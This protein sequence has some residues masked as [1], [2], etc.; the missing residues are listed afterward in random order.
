MTSFIDTNIFIYAS[1]AHPE[2]GS[3][4]RTILERVHSGEQAVTSTLV[5]SEVAWVLEAKGVQSQIKPTLERITSINNLDIV[6]YSLDDMLVA[7]TYMTSYG[8]DYN[9]AVNVSVMTRLNI[10]T[11]YTNDKKH[12]GKI[13]LIKTKFE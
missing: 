9:D 13:D 2:I 10:R 6:Q 5:L 12:L 1:T 7:P 4:A 11:C 8:I 3:A